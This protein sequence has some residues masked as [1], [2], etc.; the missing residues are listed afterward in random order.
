MPKLSLIVAAALLGQLNVFA[1]AIF[2]TGHDPDFHATEMP[3]HMTGAQNITRAA[4]Q[5]ILDPLFNPYVSTAPK[6]LFV[7]S[8][9]PAPNGH[10]PGVNGMVATG[11]TAGVHFEH[12]DAT[13]LSGELNLLGTKYAG[14]VVASDFGGLLTGAELGIL[15]SRSSDIIKF[16]N[17]G[18]GL[19]A[20]ANTNTQAQLTKGVEPYGYLPF[21]VTA[22]PT[23]QVETDFKL[24]P[25]GTSLGITDADV[26]HNYSH[27]VFT[28]AFNMSV[29]DVDSKGNIVTL[30][31]RNLVQTPVESPEPGTTALMAAGMAVLILRRK[32]LCGRLRMRN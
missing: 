3:G 14:L 10:A 13:T 27:V 12:H 20:M 4:L 25:F 24:T 21:I 5:Y 7:E 19:Y 18:G 1:G 8:R 29:V 31:T 28:Q 32:S 26:N 22:T 23:G 15:N 30:A 17:S 11:Y 9:I 2:L 6:F 16:L